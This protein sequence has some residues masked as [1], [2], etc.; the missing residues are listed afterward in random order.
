MSIILDAIR[1]TLEDRYRH[2]CSLELG[3]TASSFSN[4]LVPIWISGNILPE[5][6]PLRGVLGADDATL[7][8]PYVGVAQRF[9]PFEDETGLRSA[10]LHSL[11]LRSKL[12]RPVGQ[13]ETTDEYGS[14][15]VV[16]TWLVRSSQ[17]EAWIDAIS[18]VR[19][20]TGFSEELSFECLIY[21]LG[22]E[23]DSAKVYSFP[24]LHLALRHALSFDAEDEAGKWLSADDRV[25]RL[26]QTLPLDYSDP[27]EK[28]IARRV[29]S[30]AQ[31]RPKVD[32]VEIRVDS[33]LV[34]GTSISRLSIAN[35]RNLSLVNISFPDT[36]VRPLVIFGPNG[37]G[38]SSI[39]E[40]LALACFGISPRLER[41]CS[42][43]E[44]D[45]AS[46][47]K[48]LEFSQKYLTPM[49]DQSLKPSCSIN[50]KQIEFAYAPV[51]DHK[52][53]KMKMDRSV[54]T[55]EQSIRFSTM[56][57]A[58][59]ALHVL[60]GYSDLADVVREYVE[61]EAARASDNRQVF[62]RSLGL[63]AQ[64]IKLE[65]VQERIVESK[66][67]A[68]QLDFTVQVSAWLRSLENLLLRQ[69][70]EL[71]EQI[72][73]FRGN[74]RRA[75]VGRHVSKRSA[76]DEDRKQAILGYIEDFNLLATL[77]S[78]RINDIKERL[79]PANVD[80]DTL[81]RRLETW[82]QWIEQR[83]AE[84]VGDASVKGSEEQN[85]QVRGIHSRRIE[86]EKT[87]HD[88]QICRE[89]KA[90][91]ES[92]QRLL[93]GGWA[94]SR[95]NECPTCG[96][97]VSTFGGIAQRVG[98]LL[99]QV[100]Q[101]ADLLGLRS[102]ELRSDI[103]S[104]QASL[105]ESGSSEQPL[106]DVE[107]LA[108]VQAFQ[109]LTPTDGS[110]ETHIADAGMRRALIASAVA[111]SNFPERP[112]IRENLF[113][114]ASLTLSEIEQKWDEAASALRLPTA[115]EAVR[116]SLLTKLTQIV[117]GH[118]PQ[119]SERLWKEVTMALTSGSWVNHN[120][121]AMKA[122]TSKREQ[123]L[124]LDI[125]G[126]LP[127]YILNQCESHILGLAWFFVEY[128]LKGRFETPLVL[129]DDPAQEMDQTTYRE[130]VRFLETFVRLHRRA[131]KPLTLITMM[132]QET[133]AFELARS[134]RSYWM[135]LDW[136]GNSACATEM[137]LAYDPSSQPLN[138]QVLLPIS[139]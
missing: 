67:E 82:G 128:V 112:K 111:I 23:R 47:D 3:H 138:A 30:L 108:V 51:S 26:L 57:S 71:P 77:I 54:L 14:W 83:T 27:S 43:E 25:R 118:L 13:D 4:H 15:R 96:L 104:F 19:G 55:Q 63:S 132:H 97:D 11:D 136:R 130:F 2:D 81:I 32:E 1:Q 31:N 24:R 121:P 91:L 58:E 52:G 87:R 100:T 88:M 18:N 40:A 113:D 80:L 120:M 110:F 20:S 109:W 53:S 6:H 41:F 60:R 29:A 129:L 7:L 135:T 35:F 73:R 59:C 119:T 49:W 89:R 114:E 124:T 107:R 28:E 84:R 17:R 134:M 9:V 92:T 98:I 62:L 39:T 139:V 101:E 94:K 48:I 69:G 56:N 64:I 37:T 76:T 16:V 10:I 68:L 105:I 33:P 66:L 131:S 36:P 34:A 72:E 46:R 78:D 75:E 116:K 117:E 86:L 106:T 5:S 61:T 102:T 65:T 21:D 85:H 125:D 133:R 45:V 115:W 12:Q 123:K 74:E 126:R 70:S 44:K 8:D 50:G 93:T 38:K 79:G 99:E 95:A 103:E 42:P 137:T 127:R 122:S 22:Q 90:H